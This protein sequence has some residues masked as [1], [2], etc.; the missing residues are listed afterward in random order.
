M[1]ENN[2]NTTHNVETIELTAAEIGH[3]FVAYISNTMSKCVLTYFV[4]TTNDTDIKS[5]AETS[6]KITSA[7]IDRIKAIYKT[8][9]HPVPEGFTDKDINLK[10][11]KL[12]SDTFVLNYLRFSQQYTLIN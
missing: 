3:L 12:F 11:G 5:I 7:I 1:I 9:N 2:S 10:A 4:H 6:L 8:V